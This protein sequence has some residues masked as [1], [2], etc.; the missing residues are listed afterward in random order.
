MAHQDCDVHIHNHE[1]IVYSRLQEFLIFH[2]F[3]KN[4]KKI[5]GPQCNQDK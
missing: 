2:Y 5:F 1:S 4:V 3:T